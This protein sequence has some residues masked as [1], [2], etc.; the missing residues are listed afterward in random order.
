MC[1]SLKSVDKS[2]QCKS[3][4]LGGQVVAFALLREQPKLPSGAA[5]RCKEAVLAGDH[6]LVLA[7]AHGFAPGRLS[8]LFHLRCEMQFQLSIDF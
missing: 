3:G 8:G 2:N 5:L 4:H 6:D 1:I 7:A